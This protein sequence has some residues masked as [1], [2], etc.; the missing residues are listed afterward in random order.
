MNRD[1]KQNLELDWSDKLD[2]YN[3]DDK[4]G[5]LNNQSTDIQYYPNSAKFEDKYVFAIKGKP[6]WGK[7]NVIIFVYMTFYSKLFCISKSPYQGAFH[8]FNLNLT[9]GSRT[10]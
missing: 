3:I 9:K 8:F 7:V 2:A 1:A 4:C 5:R 6:Y 10:S